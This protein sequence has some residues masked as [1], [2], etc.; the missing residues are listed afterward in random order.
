MPR[1]TGAGNRPAFTQAD[2]VNRETRRTPS[3]SRMVSRPR[4]FR[5]RLLS[6]WNVVAIRLLLLIEDYYYLN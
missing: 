6:R 5:Q 1:S 3:T 2:S 4:H